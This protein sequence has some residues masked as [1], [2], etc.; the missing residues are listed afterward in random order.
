M[1]RIHAKRG[2]G[3]RG[4]ARRAGCA[5]A[6]VL[7]A[8]AGHAAAQQPLELRPRLEEALRRLFAAERPDGR[9][10]Q[11]VLA[12]A[13]GQEDL[14]ADV[15]R[16]K[17]FVSGR[18]AFARKGFIDAKYRFQDLTAPEGDSKPVV[19]RPPA[20]AEN[21]A[22]FFGPEL[23]TGLGPLIVFIPDATSTS[24]YEGALAKQATDP[25]RF[26][27]LV[28]DEKQDNR[29]NPSQHE[30]R[31]HS[32]PLRGLL[33]G[34]AIDPDRV[35]L[36]G[37]GRGGHAT[38]DV[39][40]VYADRWAAICPCNGGPIHEGGYKASGGVFLEN[41]KS[42]VFLTVYNTSFDHG[43]E[44]CR[45][46]TK[47]Y[48]E[49]G[50]RFEA[51]EEPQFRHMD[52]PEAMERIGATVRDAHPRELVK[53]FNHLDAGEHYWLRA[54]D[55]VPHEW[56]PSARIPILGKMPDD[57]LGRRELIWEAVKRECA[58]M[59]ATV[60]ENAFDVTATG[61]GRLRI[62]FDPELV[63]F[64]KKVTVSINGKTSDPFPIERKAEAMLQHVHE[65]GD[66]SR[67][68]WAFRDFGVRRD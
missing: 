62:W 41:A 18:G 5:L 65:T 61:V 12:L 27:F 49:W 21:P 25:G 60:K 19:P 44:G 36:V 23:K 59:K 45:Y 51:V 24:G 40:L 47:K 57:P 54:L 63:D 67:L 2:C 64:K 39:G 66:T 43:I 17:S 46:A 11:E 38:W 16:T 13:K 22:L 30:R 34:N 15:V 35:F 6:L 7:V 31:R 42:F 9:P 28:P 4:R 53:R 37:T 52:L 56:N 1:M 48:K 55:R 68:Y 8:I 32:G 50:Y 29:W 10:M 20:A 14:L 58:F 26:T 33:L 3:T